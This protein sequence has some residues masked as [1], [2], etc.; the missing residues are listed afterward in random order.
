MAFKKRGQALG[1]LGDLFKRFLFFPHG[2]GVRCPPNNR[3][4][5]NKAN[6]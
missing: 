2:K 1:S 3:Q 5:G 6:E 4:K